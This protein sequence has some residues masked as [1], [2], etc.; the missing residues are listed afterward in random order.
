MNEYQGY[1]PGDRIQMVE[2]QDRH[3]PIMPGEKGT[4]DRIDD[5]GTL[6]MR[7]DNGRTLGVCLD[8]D[9]VRK[10]SPIQENELLNT[11]PAPQCDEAQFDAH[12]EEVA[13]L[14]GAIDAHCA[15]TGG[16]WVVKSSFL[17]EANKGREPIFEFTGRES[18]FGLLD[19]CDVKNGLDI[20]V[21]TK[22][23]AREQSILLI[24]YGQNYTMPDGTTGILAE[25]LECK[26]ASPA[27]ARDFHERLDNGWDARGEAAMRLF[28]SPRDQESLSR[29]ISSC[30]SMMNERAKEHGMER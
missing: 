20:A 18:I 21:T 11:V 23:P 28:N 4:I 13:M 24:A 14:F 7:W 6:H 15:G 3:A 29:C 12:S 27:A 30:K 1:R 9:E 2:C 26:L 16:E 5:M 8:E 25:M 22:R 19:R 17:D 10:V